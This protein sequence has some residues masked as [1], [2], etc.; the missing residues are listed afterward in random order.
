MT[1][2]TSYSVP[3]TTTRVLGDP[4]HP[5]AVGR[6]DQGDVGPV[7]GLQ[8]AVAEGGPLAHVAVP[9]LQLL[10]R[11]RVR[12][13]GVDPCADLVHLLEVG[14]LVG[15]FPLL[16][17]YVTVAVAGDQLLVQACAA[18]P[19]VVDQ[20]LLDVT[21]G[22]EG[23]EVVPAAL[24]PAGRQ[25]R[26]PR[27]GRWGGCR[28]RRPRRG[29]AGTR[30]AG[31]RRRPGAARTWMAVAPVPI[32][33]TR[34]SASLCRLPVGVAAGVGVVPAA[35]V[36]RVP[37]EGLDPRDAGELGLA[38]RAAGRHH[39]PR[40]D[41]VARSVPTS[42]LAGGFV[43]L[44]SG[45]LGLE[46][47]FAVQ[48]EVPPDRPRVLPDLLPGRVL[49][50]GDVA[51]LL[52]QRQVDVRLDVAVD[53]RDTGS[54]TRYRRNPRPSR[55]PGSIPRPPGAAGRPRAGRRTRRRRRPLRPGRAAARAR[56]HLR[57][58]GPRRST[59]TGR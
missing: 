15:A 17:R 40:P 58:K 5:V 22:D 57:C 30:T 7:E 8:V 47:G 10:R 39:V 38:E 54:S 46:A 18:G 42:P 52:Q 29:C 23:E 33:A 32:R 51:D 21:A 2:S 35:G 26:R 44:Q 20:V 28:V 27:R 49:P 14:D 41:P 12:D 16:G 36:E 56:G 43:P 34:L 48:V 9:G 13:D 59:R 19:A 24:L 4:L 31:P 45:H 53:S 1:Q 3:P 50:L 6:V 55:S 37:V 11:F 25:R